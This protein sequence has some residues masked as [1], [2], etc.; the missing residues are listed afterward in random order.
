M[1]GLPPYASSEEFSAM[2]KGA[3]RRMEEPTEIELP[4]TKDGYYPHTTDIV[5]YELQGAPTPRPQRSVPVYKPHA[6]G[7]PSNAFIDEQKVLLSDMFSE[8]DLASFREQK[9]KARRDREAAA[10]A[11]SSSRGAGESYDLS[12]MSRSYR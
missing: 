11:A 10:A 4:P 2:E 6:Q 9:A 5:E 12:E 8:A 7:G 1:G 3:V